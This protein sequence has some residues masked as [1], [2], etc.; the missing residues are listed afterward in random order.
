MANSKKIER[1][2]KFEH[3]V[4]CQICGFKHPKTIQGHIRWKH[5]EIGI[6]EYMNKFDAEIVSEDEKKYRAQKTKDG[7]TGKKRTEEVKQK[8]KISHKEMWTDGMKKNQS[9][10]MKAKGISGTHPSQQKHV[11]EIARQNAIVRNKTESQISAVKKALIGKELSEEV[12]NNISKGHMGLKQSKETKE[13]MS[14]IMREK[15]ANGEMLLS[16]C[17]GV[18]HST[19]MDRDFTY[20]SSY[21]LKYFSMLD[22]DDSV[23]TWDA[24][25][26]K[27]PYIWENK[28]HTYYPDVLVNGNEIHEVKAKWMVDNDRNLVKQSAAEK[29]CKAR[30]WKYR[31]ITENDLDI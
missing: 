11:R 28:S 19:K 25:S 12:R 3:E 5:P 21:E 23:I 18:Y 30:N 2:L 8:M 14:Y 7:N 10:R 9:E 20:R 4:E 31:L 6:L 13:K 27:I 22:G 26:V 24:E 1:S 15:H 16:H 17:H 29:F